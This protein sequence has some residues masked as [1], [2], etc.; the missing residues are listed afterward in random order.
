MTLKE[1]F[2]IKTVP[3]YESADGKKFHDLGEAQSHTREQMLQ[4]A[5]RAA[6]KDRAE[7]SRLDNRLLVDFLLLAGKSV[8]AIMA[9]PLMPI[10]MNPVPPR[11]EPEFAAILRK[12]DTF[13][14]DRGNTLRVEP[15]MPKATGLREAMRNVDQD[16]SNEAL[17]DLDRQIT[18][19]M[20]G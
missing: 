8:G 17:D 20:G 12:N 6:I 4:A 19:A 11:E 9:E 2:Q 1:Q 7:F 15:A 16:L 10:V 18:A 13:Q 3:A 14:T 5:V